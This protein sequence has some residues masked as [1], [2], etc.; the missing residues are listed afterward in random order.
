MLKTGTGGSFTYPDYVIPREQA[1][2]FATAQSTRLRELA[3]WNC[4]PLDYEYS[5]NITAEI[6]DL[7]SLLNDPNLT[8]AAFYGEECRGIA[9]PVEVNDQWVLFLTQYSNVLN[10]TLTYKVF[11]ADSNEIVDVVETLPFVN[12]QILGNP[13]DPYPFYI[14]MGELNAPQNLALVIEGNNLSLTWDAVPGAKSY[15]VYVGDSPDGR[16]T[17]VSSLGSFGRAIA[18]PTSNDTLS[19]APNRAT[20]LIWTCDIPQGPGKFYHI[21]ANTDPR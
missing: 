19:A 6:H 18:A 11:L 21:K 3:G 4:N 16:F 17:E 10:Q 20:R 1:A 7:N 2:D 9:T 13:F 12:N 15:K 14:N 8:I 5:S